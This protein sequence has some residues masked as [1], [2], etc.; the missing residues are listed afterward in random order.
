MKFAIMRPK[1]YLIGAGPGDPELITIKGMKILKRARAVLYDALVSEEL[2]EMTSPNTAKIYVGKRCGAHSLKQEEIN[3]LIVQSAY[4]YGEVVRL[5]GGD[6]FVFGRGFEEVNYLSSFDIDVEVIPGLSSSTCLTTIQKVPLTARN[7]AQSFWVLTASTKEHRLSKD[8][9]LAAK[10]T[11]TLVI[12][13]G[14]R[15]IDMIVRV[16]KKYR[17]GKEPCMVIQA[18]TCKNESVLID[19]VS[20]L[21]AQRRDIN[22]ALPGVIVIGEVVGLHPKF[23]YQKVMNTW[24]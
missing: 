11:A 24:I 5:K 6:P 17:K 7:Y 21:N 9:K 3:L 20:N 2:L 4:E 15:K 22:P 14:I 1:V 19:V 16:M 8:I 13:M 12:L 18:G 10:S 23:I